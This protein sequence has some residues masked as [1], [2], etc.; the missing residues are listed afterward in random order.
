M[1]KPSAMEKS[2]AQGTR[3]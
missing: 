1:D 3:L 2:M